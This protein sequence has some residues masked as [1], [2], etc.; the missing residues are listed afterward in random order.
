MATL[1]TFGSDWDFWGLVNTPLDEIRTAYHVT[2]LDAAQVARACA[3]LEV[4]APGSSEDQEV[5]A[6]ALAGCDA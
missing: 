6:A 3:S 4:V 1:D 2:P 5:T